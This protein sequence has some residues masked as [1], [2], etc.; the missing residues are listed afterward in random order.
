ME[1]VRAAHRVLMDR[2]LHGPGETDPRQRAQAF[3]NA[4]VDAA[5]QP[6]IGKVATEPTR[7]TDADLDVAGYTGDEIFEMVVAAAVGEA[8]QM[9][10]SALAA[11]DEA[12]AG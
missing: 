10:E 7:I 2:V 6:L 9:Y 12:A 11:L 3:A 5:L 4:G 1:D 8:T